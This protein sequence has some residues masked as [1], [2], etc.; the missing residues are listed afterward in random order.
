[1]PG[2]P[3]WLPCRRWWLPVGLALLVGALA[4]T[5]KLLVAGAAI[6]AGEVFLAKVRLFRVPELLAGSFVL[7]FLSVTASYMIG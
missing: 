3:R 4:L 6:A 1:M 2:A 7:A 5:G